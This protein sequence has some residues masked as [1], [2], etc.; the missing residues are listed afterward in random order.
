[1]IVRLKNPI[2]E[3]TSKLIFDC[4]EFNTSTVKIEHEGSE[5][6]IPWSNVRSLKLNKVKIEVKKESKKKVESEL[7]YLEAAT[8][9]PPPQKNLPNLLKD[10]KAKKRSKNA[11][12]R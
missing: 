8:L 5:L 2:D 11:R 7:D 10:P 9:P 4:V 12:K 6:L 1:M 3:K